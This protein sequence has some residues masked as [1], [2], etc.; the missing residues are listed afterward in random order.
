MAKIKINLTE[1]HIKLIKNFK[2]ERINDIY[3]GV[4]TINPYGGSYLM[5]DLAMML[6]YWDKAVE[7]TE[8]DYDGRKFGL[9]NEQEM[10]EIHNYVMNNMPFILSILIQFSTDIVKPGVYTSLDYNIFWE[11]KEENK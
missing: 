4:D 8:K 11:Y 9:D 2:V 10:I 5:E 7:G 6:G 1:N 3:V